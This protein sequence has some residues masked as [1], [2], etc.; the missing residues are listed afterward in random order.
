MFFI[1]LRVLSE[2]LPKTW[3]SFVNWTVENCPISS[4]IWLSIQKLFWVRMKISKSF[5]HH[6]Q[7]Q[8]LQ[9]IQIWR[10]KWPSPFSISCQQ[11]VCRHCWVTRAVCTKPLASRWICCSIWQR[12]VAAFHE[13][14]K[15]KVINNFNYCLKKNIT[16]KITSQWRHFSFKLIPFGIG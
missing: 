13:L 14:W 12:F 6:S 15:Q 4:P 16:F 7:T 3:G 10:V 11:Y 5:L 8:Y 2:P 1:S 9:G